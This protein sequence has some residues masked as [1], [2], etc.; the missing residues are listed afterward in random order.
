MN[1]NEDH[2]PTTSIKN[3]P[4]SIRVLNVVFD[5]I[6]GEDELCIFR[7]ALAERVGL[8][9][10]WFHNHNNS[11]EGSQFYYRYP[12]IQYKLKGNQPMLVC[13]GQGVHAASMFFEQE[14]WSLTMKG[15]YRRLE[16]EELR[17]KKYV[18]S[19]AP[20][21]GDALPY[22]Y[23]IKRWQALNQNN[24]SK[25][26][27]QNGLRIMVDFLESLLANHIISFAKG[28]QWRIPE[29]FEVQISEMY[30]VRYPRFKG[31]RPMV[32]DFTF[33][34]NLLLPDFIGIG[35]GV[36]LGYGTIKRIR[37]RKRR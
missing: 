4:T 29:R 10:D 17:L 9:H 19:V 37:S 14:D 8:E 2:I 11:D 28:I 33:E 13:I 34:S 24:Y 22:K 27:Q 32:F 7:G 23:R 15:Q 3:I 21:E 31:I 20:L 12:L 1:V 36:S 5:T 35:K 30:P 18:L 6:L 25:Y 26:P 16:I